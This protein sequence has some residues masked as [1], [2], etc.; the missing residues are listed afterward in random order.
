MP[1]FLDDKGPYEVRIPTG[2]HPPPHVHVVRDDSE[3]KFEF[4]PSITVTEN[5]GF[6]GHELT[7]IRDLLR[8][9][10]TFL[11]EKWHEING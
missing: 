5:W 10:R 2:D 8:E 6:A 11:L 9:H 7:D 3:A 4:H 1:S